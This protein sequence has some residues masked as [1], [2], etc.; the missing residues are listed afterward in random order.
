MAPPSRSN[1]GHSGFVLLHA[2]WLLLLAS[3][4]GSTMMAATLGAA[5]DGAAVI[6]AF[7]T[8]MAA[9][10]AFHSALYQAL[11]PGYAP[12]ARSQV[13]QVDAID[14]TVTIK[15]VSG[16]LDI[17]ASD[18]PT[19]YRLLEAL[20]VS[21]TRRMVAGLVAARPI[22]SYAALAAVDGLTQQAFDTIFPHVTLFSR[23][24]MPSADTASAWLAAT[25]QLKQD[26]P[27]VL[28]GIPSAAGR[29]FR[30]E[31]MAKTPNA[32]SRQLVVEFLLTGRRDQ[33][34]WI[35]EWGWHTL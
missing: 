4:L 31:A 11:L 21:D 8:E 7:R 30:F 2:L 24:A 14:V 12:P 23:Q 29:V 32:S 13:I 26:S 15:D 28:A 27:G 19:L 10:S 34:Y 3:L 1:P 22:T 16:L 5:K 25:L 35:Y 17:N 9:E 20:A 6:S 18:E 33:P